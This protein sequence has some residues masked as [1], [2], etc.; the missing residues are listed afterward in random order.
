MC[1]GCKC[2]RIRPLTHHISTT[3]LPEHP[4]PLLTNFNSST[5][6]PLL[7]N[8]PSTGAPNIMTPFATSQCGRPHCLR[9]LVYEQ[10]PN[11]SSA[12]AS[13]VICSVCSLINTRNGR[14]DVV[15]SAFKLLIIQ[16]KTDIFK[17]QEHV[18]PH[19]F[20]TFLT[21]VCWLEKML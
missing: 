11:L 19:F 4:S 17:A 3:V 5:L 14:L 12:E 10:T 9:F 2:G 15:Q 7:S 21:K 18:V 8:L 6:H 16:H 20:F 13:H 1:F